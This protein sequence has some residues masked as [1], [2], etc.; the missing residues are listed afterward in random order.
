[1]AGELA[2]GHA[3]DNFCGEASHVVVEIDRMSARA[4]QAEF[5]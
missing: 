3:N 5:V 4:N 2:Y 1:M